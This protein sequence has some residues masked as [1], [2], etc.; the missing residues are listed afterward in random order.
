MIKIQAVQR[1][2]RV[3]TKTRNKREREAALRIQNRQ[4]QRMAFRVLSD[5]QLFHQIYDD[6]RNVAIL[7]M[8][9]TPRNHPSD[10]GT[11]LFPG[12]R[13]VRS[14]FGR[15]SSG[16]R[17]VGSGGGRRRGSATC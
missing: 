16:R 8:Q 10:A 15:P 14:R 17:V 12:H 1:G 6:R 11:L 9:V 3:M 4:R 2:K 5:M 13:G 7:Q